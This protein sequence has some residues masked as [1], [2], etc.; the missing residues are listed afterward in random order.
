MGETFVQ[1]LAKGEIFF[2]GLFVNSVT[3]LFEKSMK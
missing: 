3:G 1:K 2:Q